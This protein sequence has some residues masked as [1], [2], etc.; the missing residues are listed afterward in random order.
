MDAIRLARA[1]YLRV[2]RV[3]PG[4]Y[5]VTGGAAEHTVRAVAGALVCDCADAAVHGGAECK[6]CLAVR[7]RRG[8][9]A[10]LTALRALVAM[11]R[12]KHAR[13]KVAA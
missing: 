5:V 3:G 10:A 11:P 8:D 9:P 13:R 7:L 6:H 12:R 1:V 4:H 2:E